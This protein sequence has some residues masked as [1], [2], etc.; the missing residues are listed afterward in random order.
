MLYTT[1]QDIAHTLAQ[2][3]Q[4]HHS[5]INFVQALEI[6]KESG[7]LTEEKT[8]NSWNKLPEKWDD[9][10][11]E[12]YIN[13]LPVEVDYILNNEKPCEI[14]EKV[15]IPYG[16]DVFAFIH[17]PYQNDI[18]HEHNYFEINYVYRGSLTQIISNEA[19]LMN[20]GDFCIISPFTQHSVLAA[21]DSLVLSIQLRKTTFDAIFGSFLAKTDLLA[22]FFK[23]TLY[24]TNQ[25][26]YLYFHTDNND[27]I[28]MLIQNIVREA[29]TDDNYSS[30][31]CN[32]YVQILFSTLLRKYGKSALYYGFNE[33]DSIDTD[34]TFI[35][36]YITQHYRTVTL[37]ELSEFS[38]YSKPYLSSLFKKNMNQTFVNVL[39]NIKMR[40]ALDFLA[41]TEK[42]IEEIGIEVGYNSTDHFSRSFK[43]YNHCSPSEFRKKIR[44][45]QGRLSLR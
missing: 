23:N 33:Q 7:M 12:S 29:N 34:F 10:V 38:H 25:S 41:N 31:C 26:N 35:L 22:I 30:T 15:L 36:E 1:I 32:G 11:F 37:D 27:N 3:H 39:R 2:H 4:V 45:Q 40:H 28:K 5:D 14:T 21:K 6:L 9:S 13:H 19:R 24:E 18:L 44:E 16:R 42:T 17:L 8:R 43:Q 20:E